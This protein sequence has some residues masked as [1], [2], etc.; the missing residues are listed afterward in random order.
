MKQGFLEIFEKGDIAELI[1]YMDKEFGVESYSLLNLFRDEQRKILEIAFSRK[2]EEFEDAYRHLYEENK[3]LMGFMRD[4]G[5]PVPK[6]FMAAVEFNLVA[7]IKKEFTKRDLDGGRIKDIVH[8]AG[9][10][11]VAL[12]SGVEFM[13]RRKGE[14]LIGR[15]KK[16][17]YDNDL[18]M[19]FL[20]FLEILT[21]MPV[22]VN[23]WIMQ[24]TY[25]E[26]AQHAYG[27]LL[28]KANRGGEPAKKWIE[29]FR[30]TGELLF[31]NIKAIL[32]PYE[33][34]EQAA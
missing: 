25:D 6:G 5:M 33:K 21:A 2:A 16:T 12:D 17:P 22:E 14:R 26:I 4:A 11:H 23:L 29:A 1:R 15:L 10:W 18:L 24:N 31:F 9:E 19:E 32:A 20:A 3:T 30:R 13:I 34:K 8:D 27:D 28:D 7:R